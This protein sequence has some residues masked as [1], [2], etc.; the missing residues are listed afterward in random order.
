MIT[1][2][3]SLCLEVTR[4]HF[5]TN[6]T[7]YPKLYG[8]I[9][10]WET[11]GLDHNYD[12]LLLHIGKMDFFP[13][14]LVLTYCQVLVQKLKLSVNTFVCLVIIKERIRM[15]NAENGDLRK[16]ISQKSLESEENCVMRGSIISDQ[17][18]SSTVIK[19]KQMRQTVHVTRM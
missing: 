5:E 3:L 1:P 12:K 11:F 18:K 16:T 6:K 9:Q 2:V 4:I 14:S 15:E 7:N 19:S 17:P 13:Q 8:F 10:D